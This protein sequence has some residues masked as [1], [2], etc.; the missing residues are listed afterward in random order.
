MNIYKKALIY[1]D[2][3]AW[4]RTVLEG[5]VGKATEKKIKMYWEDEC[6]RHFECPSCEY[7]LGEDE[8]DRQIR[9]CPEC[10]QSLDWT[11]YDGRRFM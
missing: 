9:Y 2:K 1:Y 6:I 5:L 7:D 11:E 10:G 8:V 4:A 3:Q